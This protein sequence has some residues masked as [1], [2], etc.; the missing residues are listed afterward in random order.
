L[1][2]DPQKRLG[3]VEDAKEIKAH[4]F[5]K[6]I[7]WAQLFQKKLEPPFKPQVRKEGLDASNFDAEFTELPLDSQSVEMESAFAGL[8]YDFPAFTYVGSPNELNKQPHIGIDLDEKK[9]EHV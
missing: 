4:P 1:N 2:R 9:Y 7:D 8:E 6:E 5:F 3:S